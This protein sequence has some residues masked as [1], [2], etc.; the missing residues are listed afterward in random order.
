M[1]VSSR[2]SASVSNPAPVGNTAPVREAEGNERAANAA[3][4]T[5]TQLSGPAQLMSKLSQLRDSAP[6]QFSQVV[7][8]LAADLRDVAAQ[9]TGMSAKMLTALAS[10]LDGLASSGDAG[11]AAGSTAANA[12]RSNASADVPGTETARAALAKMMDDLDAALKA[13]ASNDR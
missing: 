2:V 3:D 5:N 4:A 11:H 10:R 6:A 13:S 7:S 9:D 8:G 1:Y 12:Y